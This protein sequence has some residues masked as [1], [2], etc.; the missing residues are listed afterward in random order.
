MKFFGRFYLIASCALCLC[1]FPRVP[2]EESVQVERLRQ[3]LSRVDGEPLAVIAVLDASTALDHL[4]Q[5]AT[6][7]AFLDPQFAPNRR[8]T[9]GLLEEHL[10]AHPEVIWDALR[11]HLA[12]PMALILTRPDG[13]SGSAPPIQLSL[14]V[15]VKDSGSVE[16]VKLGWPE[17]S[18]D[19][20]HLLGQVAL[21]LLPLETLVKA[22]P[23]AEW[24]DRCSRMNGEILLFL[25][26]RA[27]AETL[28]ALFAATSETP[29]WMKTLR[30]A[31]SP[32][33][34]RLT[35]NLLPEG[36]FCVE[37]VAC[38][39]A[40]GAQGHLARMLTSL[41]ADPQPWEALAGALPGKQDAH[42]LLQLDLHV[43]GPDLPLLM[44]SFERTLRGKRWTNLYGGSREALDPN[45][46]TFLSKPWAGTFGVTGAQSASGETHV[47]AAAA[48]PDSKAE[49]RR[50]VLLDELRV[51]GLSFETSSRAPTIGESA[52]LAASFKGRGIMPAPV[53]GLT[54][55]WSWLC[56]STAAY[57]DLVA[58]LG[59]Q[60]GLLLDLKGLFA[61]WA[62]SP[63]PIRLPEVSAFVMHVDLPR[64]GPMAYTSWMLSESGQDLFGW[65]VPASLLPSPGFLKKHLG[66]YDAVAVRSGQ[67][68]RIFAR[69][70]LPGGSLLPLA[71]L[72]SLASEMRRVISTSPA[73]VRSELES[74]VRPLEAPRQGEQP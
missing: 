50:A 25:R 56:S 51:L 24:A 42:I 6:G 20:N 19:S 35:L 46:F 1:G 14:W 8:E 55:G 21:K 71:T 9:M 43:L 31:C 17:V 26:S 16:A 10:G 66:P 60:N 49:E 37:E 36:R 18:P 72:G 13:R 29:P 48:E 4:K 7:R 23:V 53:I 58:A 64:V 32:D 68:V 11:P 5:T 54:D 73:A 65:K 57:H 70:P 3:L 45:R 63:S 41:R 59:A 28:D 67:T 62:A 22:Q 12:G 27:L 47:V 69:G 40:P 44:Q 2:A 33:L 30:A 15:A 61:Q 38:E 39:L 52:P 74:L 34:E